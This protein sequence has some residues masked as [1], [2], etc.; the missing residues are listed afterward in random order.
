MQ[1]FFIRCLS[2]YVFVALPILSL[3]QDNPALESA[4]STSAASISYQRDVWP[5][6]RRHCRGCHSRTDA[7]GG[8]SMDSVADMLKGGDGGPSFTPGKA[9]GNLLLEMISG[10][11]P[12]MPK[13]Q[14][15]LSAAKV[16]IIR[17]WILS[18]AKDDA[19]LGDLTPKVVI[20]ETYMFAPAV[21]S[22]AISPDGARIAAAC[23]SELV[24]FPV[25]GDTPPE[26]I[27]TE[28]DLL[29]HVEFSPDGTRL[30]AV[31]GSPSSFGEVRFY[32]AKSGAL[33]YSRRVGHDTLFRGAFSP[34]GTAVA[35]GGSDGAAHIVPFDQASAVKSF[36]LHSDW[37]F[38]VDWTPDGKMLV[39]GGRDKATKVSSVETGKLLRSVDMSAERV[40]TV[41]CTADFA[42]SS[43]LARTLSGFEFKIALSGIEVT[44]AGNGARPITNR[45]QYVRGMESQPGE[46]FTM[47]TSL[48]RKL[49][50]IGGAYREIRVYKTDDRTRITLIPNLPATVYSVS[51]NRDGTR[52]AAGGRDGQVLIY[53]IPSGTL[54]RSLVPVPVA[55]TAGVTA[56]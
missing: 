51:L 7:K 11:Q 35:V 47:A 9:D 1:R 31:G 4:R 27:P 13:Q 39:T 25:E 46:V 48:D 53:E 2:F 23:R 8:L 43:G 50:A 38:D 55:T 3:G 28:C 52:L 45:A 29:T 21:T 41:S 42:F 22:V 33:I 19:D 24:L 14:P 44:G 6:V 18:G 36:P 56:S 5:I 15:A 12:E 49:L 54:I 37:V 32:D 40:Q 17:K 10:D 34:D 16:E 20:P 30:V 26:R